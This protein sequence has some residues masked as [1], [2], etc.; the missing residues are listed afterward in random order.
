MLYRPTCN[1]F[2]NCCDLSLYS[3]LTTWKSSHG[4]KNTDHEALC[5]FI[6]S[7]GLVL[8][9]VCKPGGG[10]VKWTVISLSLLCFADCYAYFCSC[11]SFNWL[12]K[13]RSICC[14]NFIHR[15]FLI[16]SSAVMSTYTATLSICSVISSVMSIHSTEC[17]L[18]I[19]DYITSTGGTSHYCNCVYSGENV[20]EEK[21]FI[22]HRKVHVISKGI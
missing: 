7:L 5:F 4:S 22:L 16:I 3:T 9:A 1:A 2:E 19:V 14:S 8:T 10:Q 18:S 20:E 17:G 13:I 12:L 15:S 11:Y 21:A 6:Y